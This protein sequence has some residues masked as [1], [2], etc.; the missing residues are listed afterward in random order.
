MVTRWMAVVVV[1]SAF[2]YPVP[3]AAQG[4]MT[5]NRAKAILVSDTSQRA[6]MFRAASHIFACLDDAPGTIATGLRRATSGSMQDT[7]LTEDASIL[8]DRRLVDSVRALAVDQSQALA[9]RKR[10][11]LLLTRYIWPGTGI[12]FNAAATGKLLALSASSYRNEFPGSQPIDGSARERALAGIYSMKLNDSDAGLR[13]LAS[14]VYD[15]LSH[16]LH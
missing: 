14:M 6:N 4:S 13:A 7:V 2:A 15:E 1:A 8:F 16:R 5:C 9:K 10:Y 11:L 12:D 3:S